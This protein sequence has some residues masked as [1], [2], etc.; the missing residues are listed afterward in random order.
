MPRK[1]IGIS[2]FHLEPASVADLLISDCYRMAVAYAPYKAGFL[3]QAVRGS[4]V[5]YAV[6]PLEAV[7]ATV[8]K[9]STHI[10]FHPN[11]AVLGLPM[12]D[13]EGVLAEYRSPTHP[14]NINDSAFAEDGWQVFL[15]E[16]Q[17]CD[18]SPRFFEMTAKQQTMALR[19]R[20]EDLTVDWSL[21]EILEEVYNLACSIE[22]VKLQGRGSWKTCDIAVQTLAETLDQLADRFG[23]H[24]ESRLLQ[25]ENALLASL[26]RIRR[27]LR[28]SSEGLNAFV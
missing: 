11:G 24:Y 9:E 8:P 26:S 27:T 18:N 1:I 6:A 16:H 2:L 12:F 22:C 15:E 25:I 23:D 7:F 19:K 28:V 21:E 14:K 20:L 4:H 3:V 13:R 10:W 5:Q 17:D